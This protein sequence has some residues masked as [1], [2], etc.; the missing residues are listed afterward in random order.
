RMSTVLVLLA[1]LCVGATSLIA[2]EALATVLILEGADLSAAT[3]AQPAMPEK[4]PPV[5][6]PPEAAQSP[7]PPVAPAKEN[8]TPQTSA[9][10]PTML[11]P[12]SG[13]SLPA[14]GLD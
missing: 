4:T 6:Q 10:A 2:S 13:A 11:T 1:G 12:I 14:P 9:A 5:D 7:D 3:S 8:S